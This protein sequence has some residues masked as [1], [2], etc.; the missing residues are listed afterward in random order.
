[1][2]IFL[3]F[4]Y[5]LN[6]IWQCC[7]KELNFRIHLFMMSIAILLSICFS[8]SKIEWVL[9][10]MCCM[11]VVVTEMINTALENIGDHINKAFHPTIKIIKD[12]AAGAVLV[13]AIGSSIIGCIIFIPKI[14]N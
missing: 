6:G 7:K 9:I 2:K 1:M 3:S 11:S 14:F 8:I 13:S 10:V 5:A 12:I 4:G